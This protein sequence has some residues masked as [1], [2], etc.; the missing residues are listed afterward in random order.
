MSRC[1]T[2]PRHAPGTIWSGVGESNTDGGGTNR[3]DPTEWMYDSAIV[4]MQNANFLDDLSTP[5]A[6]IPTN[7]ANPF[8]AT[9]WNETGGRFFGEQ[10]KR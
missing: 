10:L 9:S 8:T 7:L 1:G 5:I 3:V 2:R 4:T 6:A